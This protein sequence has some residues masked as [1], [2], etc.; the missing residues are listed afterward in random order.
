MRAAILLLSGL[1]LAP[2]VARA[3]PAAC[4]AAIAAVEQAQ[5]LPAGL[6][7]AIATAESGRRMPGAVRAEPWPWAI[8]IGGESRYAESRAEAVALVLAAR[9]QGVRQVDVGCMQISLAHHPAA[10]A[11]L[12]DAFDPA[13][14]VA[15]GA[16]FLADL[17]ARS[18]DW[19]DAIGRYH[20]GTPERAAIYRERVLALL[21]GRPAAIA[22]GRVDRVSVMVSPA[23]LSVRIVSPGGISA[24]AN[25]GGAGRLPQV[26]TPTRR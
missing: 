6:L 25:P 13:T 1:V 23:A 7:T 5:D 24:G 21:E 12:E 10:F 22:A 19:P 4:L 9:A 17:R 26:V 15:Y 2:G 11:T 8:N 16:R 18:A 3:D 14:N 20:S